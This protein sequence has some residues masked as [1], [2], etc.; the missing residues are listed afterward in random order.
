M[1]RK[2]VSARSAGG[3]QGPGVVPEKAQSQPREESWRG[4]PGVPQRV[5]VAEST[6]AIWEAFRTSPV[7]R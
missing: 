4:S 6:W 3:T 7:I 5:S 1:R 2:G